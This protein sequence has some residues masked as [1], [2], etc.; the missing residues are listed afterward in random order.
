MK[1]IAGLF[2]VFFLFSASLFSQ[3]YVIE[4]DG[5]T[6]S[7]KKVLTIIPFQNNYYRSEI[8]RSLAL[9]EEINFNTLRDRLRNELDRQLYVVLQEDFDIVSFLKDDTEEDRELLNYIFYSTASQYTHLENDEAVDRRMLANGQIKETPEQE[10]Q[11]YMKTVI[12]H[13]PLLS[14]MQESAPSDW[15]LF[16]GE[17]DILILGLQERPVQP[18]PTYQQDQLP[19]L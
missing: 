13:P 11:S 19:L 15:F 12:H 1:S 6:D 16:I 10:G 17:M 5:L 9:N 7:I 18:S 4:D 14:T 8:D 2:V 3:D